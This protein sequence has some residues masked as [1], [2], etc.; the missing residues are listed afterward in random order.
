M[1][2]QTK[3]KNEARNQKFKFGD[4]VSIKIDHVDK[5]KSPLHSNLPLGKIVEVEHYAHV[6][7]KFGRI[8]TV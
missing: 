2:E 7:T 5:K 8:N 6:V 1:V 3:K 4:F